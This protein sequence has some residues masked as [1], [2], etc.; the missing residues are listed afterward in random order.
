M[1]SVGNMSFDD[2]NKFVNYIIAMTAEEISKQDDE[3]LTVLE[4]LW[5]DCI[6]DERRSFI[7][8]K[9]KAM[10]NDDISKDI[11]P[12]YY[13]LSA[14]EFELQS[15]DHARDWLYRIRDD[16]T[17]VHNTKFFENYFGYYDDLIDSHRKLKL[18]MDLFIYC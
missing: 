15:K 18:G 16:P 10:T 11:A 6:I 12:A 17:L 1:Y 8:D 2:T 5:L 7:D 4:E 3:I 13:K 14:S 9:L